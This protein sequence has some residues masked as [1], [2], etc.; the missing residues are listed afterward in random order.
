MSNFGSKN[1]FSS[2]RKK[3]PENNQNYQPEAH[4]I[5]RPDE[6]KAN[7]FSR[8]YRPDYAGSNDR[9]RGDAENL[10][11]IQMEI[12]LYT[13]RNAC[14]FAEKSWEW[15]E[16]FE[17]RKVLEPASDDSLV[18][19]RCIF[20]FDSTRSV[21]AYYRVV[22]EEDDKYI[23]VACHTN[24]HGFHRGDLRFVEVTARTVTEEFEDFNIIGKLFLGDILAVT[25]LKKIRNAP[26]DPPDARTV[27]QDSRMIWEVAEMRVLERKL[28][29][30]TV[31]AFMKNGSAIL[32]GRN[33]A[34]RVQTSHQEYIDYDS[35]YNG[36]AFIPT[37]L[38]NKFTDDYSPK[39]KPK[40]LIE[41]ARFP[42]PSALPT[43]YDYTASEDLSFRFDIG[44]NAFITEHLI[45][46]N[47]TVAA[48][49]IT[50]L[51]TQM[52]QSAVLILSD[53]RADSRMFAILNPSKDETGV[54]FSIPNPV[55]HP[56]EGLWNVN[57][58]IR[59]EGRFGI[60]DATIETVVLDGNERSLQMYARVSREF[61]G[62]INFRYGT[63]VVSQR[64]ARESPMLE[65]GYLGKM[66]DNNGRKII[67][68]LY[69]GPSLQ[70]EV[71]LIDTA[72]LC[73][74]PSDPPVELNEF[75]NQYVSLMTSGDH[76][77]ILGSSPFGC[78]KSM[79]IVTASIEKC[80]SHEDSQQL[81]ITQSN[82]ASVNLID[83]ARKAKDTKMR[84]MRYVTDTNW[85]ELPEHCRTEYDLPVLVGTVFGKLASG[86]LES[87]EDFS[88]N[89]RTVILAYLHWKQ[90]LIEGSLN[91]V[92]YKH[93]VM[94]KEDIEETPMDR[95][96]KDVSRML[97]KF[98]KPN[99]IVITADTLQSAMDCSTNFDDVVMCQIDEACQLQECT[100]ISL[101]RLFPDA[102]YGLIGDIKQLPPFCEDELKGK[103]KEYGIGNTME[104]AIKM[105]MFPEAILRF[106]YRC[107]PKT[108]ELLSDL[109]Y[110]GKLISGVK[111]DQRNEFMINRPDFWPNPHYPIIVVHNRDK[112]YKIGTSWGNRAEKIL[113]KQIVKELLKEKDG[114]KLEPSEI[115]VISFYAGQTSI[116]SNSFRGT[117]IKC[118][119]VDAF[120]GSEREVIILCCTNE[121]I[122]E[123]M[124]LSNRLN[125][126]MSRARQA[127]IIIGN[128][129][130]LSEAKYWK[131]IVKKVEANECLADTTKLPFYVSPE[132]MRRNQK[133]ERERIVLETGEDDEMEA[134]F[135][136]LDIFE[137]AETR[138][139]SGQ[140][141]YEKQ[142]DRTVNITNHPTDHHQNQQRNQD[143]HN[144]NTTRRAP[145]N[146][147]SNQNEKGPQVRAQN[148]GRREAPGNTVPRTEVAMYMAR[149]VPSGRGGASKRG[150]ASNRG[151]NSPRSSE[152]VVKE[153]NRNNNVNK[154]ASE[155]AQPSSNLRNRGFFANGKLRVEQFDE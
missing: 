106:V 78:G 85:K 24:L 121:R 139:H 125:V 82:Y 67:E 108:T 150:G 81:L 120:Q 126:A 110:D 100:L 152:L 129:N 91:E 18:P 98:Y 75:Q 15:A 147:Q 101:L 127:T 133:P 64:E 135:E 116:L 90:I 69:G 103:L 114:F 137:N 5:E 12:Q 6:F 8:F 51:C 117:G 140:Q 79:T 16:N 151:R 73:V 35:L 37:K 97:F 33:E 94:N 136:N 25:K 72:P 153:D 141:N 60:I 7:Y 138:T 80:K 146:R 22:S 9:P 113:A 74:F 122:S 145:R 21:R 71:L 23:L 27:T 19:S 17:E 148:R 30:N 57:N 50:E 95:R 34:A 41:S 62:M 1:R 112:S 105:K 154:P 43:I 99:V 68:T 29:R 11:P 107:H 10:G 32:K 36:S 87:R 14:K 47:D 58:R 144:L 104:R 149:N 119:T 42:C 53:G 86:E 26:L 109:F 76:P 155:S 44:R 70:T 118:G 56:T 115:G 45:D 40:L 4:G 65:D 48:E 49:N 38:L 77:L 59:F 88:F 143:E 89:D 131:D 28:E 92:F 2:N 3:K 46:N 123:F 83:I 102:N 39:Y 134:D 132:Q 20:K 130:G 55:Q 66:R 128:L 96:M 54:K 63:V 61:I 52:G 111:E 84:V 13:H 93:F 124:Q 142:N 31:F